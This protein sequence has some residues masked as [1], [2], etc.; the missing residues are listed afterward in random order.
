[1][2]ARGFILYDADLPRLKGFGKGMQEHI[3][4][5]FGSVVFAGVSAILV[6]QILRLSSA[7]LVQTNNGQTAGRVIGALVHFG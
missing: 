2:R 1:M 4:T 7:W 5:G 3:H 6:I